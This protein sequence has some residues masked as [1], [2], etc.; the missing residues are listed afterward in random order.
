MMGDSAVVWR[1]SR[2]LSAAGC[3]HPP[4]LQALAGGKR[5]RMLL[6]WRREHCAAT[7][8]GCCG[9]RGQAAAATSSCCVEQLSMRLEELALRRCT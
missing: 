3:W 8:P 7:R 2:L 1:N 5:A 4:L 6:T 9:N